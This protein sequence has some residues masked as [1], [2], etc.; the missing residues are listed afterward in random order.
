MNRIPLG[1][2]ISSG[3]RKIRIFY[4]ARGVILQTDEQVSTSGV[5]EIAMVAAAFPAAVTEFQQ[6]FAVGLRFEDEFLSRANPIWRAAPGAGPAHKRRRRQLLDAHLKFGRM[7]KESEDGPAADL[8]VHLH[9]GGPPGPDAFL[10]GDG[11]INRFRRSSDAD[12]MDKVG[13]HNY[14][15]FL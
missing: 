9:V 6:H 10:G 12:A 13:G 7:V 4:A 8:V 5:A 2:S 15:R 14:F 1:F 3:S 11:A